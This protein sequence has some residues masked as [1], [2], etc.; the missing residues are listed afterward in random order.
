MSY[1]I[2]NNKN[3][4]SD[5]TP[6]SQHK[7]WLEFWESKK[8]CSADKCE[9]ENCSANAELGGHVITYGK[10]AKEYI[11]PMCSSCHNKPSGEKFKAWE[12]YLIS[13]N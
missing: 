12:S 3:A 11:L 10:G 9:V 13:V 7:S 2:I 6:P 8:G 1:I 5:N 4:T